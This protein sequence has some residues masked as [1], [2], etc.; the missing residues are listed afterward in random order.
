ME[1]RSIGKEGRC[2]TFSVDIFNASLIVYIMLVA[3]VHVATAWGADHFTTPLFK[4]CFFFKNILNSTYQ[5]RIWPRYRID[6]DVFFFFGK[7]HRA[8]IQQMYLPWYGTAGY[9]FKLGLNCIFT[10][11]VE[12][13]VKQDYH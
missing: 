4:V 2:I 3:Q 11:W 13:L 1:C 10:P 5:N 12:P 7:T 8:P 9:P 6:T